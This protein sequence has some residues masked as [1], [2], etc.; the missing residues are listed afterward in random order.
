MRIA[1]KC[2]DEQSERRAE[3]GDLREREVN[4]DDPSLHDVQSQ[5]RVNAGHDEAGDDRPL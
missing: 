3:R 1:A 5:V 4:E 2:R